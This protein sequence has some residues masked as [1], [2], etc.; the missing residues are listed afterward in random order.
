MTAW[1][2]DGKLASCS[3]TSFFCGGMLC[4]TA[5]LL[6]IGCSG[7]NKLGRQAISGQVTLDGQPLATGSIEFAPK[8]PMGHSGGTTISDGQYAISAEK[9]LPLG[10]YWV[11]IFSPDQ[12]LAVPEE[13]MVPGSTRDGP[14]QPPAAVDRI[15]PR[16]NMETELSID[17]TE[18]GT[19]EF[20][21]ELTSRKK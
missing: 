17:I 1:P 18:D 5:L 7:G 8:D 6:S 15:P 14:S 12:A 16:Y 3:P 20:T 2:L 9:G 21:F 13:V 10:S 11:R 19:R 4:T